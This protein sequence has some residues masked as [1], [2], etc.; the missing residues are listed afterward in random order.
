MNS[1][2]T[3]GAGVSGAAPRS[4]NWRIVDIVV[5]SVLGVACGFVCL[6]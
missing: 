3:S 6:G 4:L 1:V 5:A 2:S